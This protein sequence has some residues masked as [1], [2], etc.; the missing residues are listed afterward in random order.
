M[1][2][3]KNVT[4]PINGD[5]KIKLLEFTIPDDNCWPIDPM[6]SFDFVKTDGAVNTNDLGNTFDDPNVPDTIKPFDD[7]N[8]VDAFNA[9]DCVNFADSSTTFDANATDGAGG[10]DCF[11]FDETAISFDGCN[12]TDPSTFADTGKLADP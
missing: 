7:S 6:N 12:F 8:F 2:D 1:D 5:D 9:I 10:A 11:G 3:I 4:L